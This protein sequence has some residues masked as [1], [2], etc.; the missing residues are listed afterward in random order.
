M[1]PVVSATLLTQMVQKELDENK[2]LTN[3]QRARLMEAASRA[4][5]SENR[6]K[7]QKGK[8]RQK[9]AKQGIKRGAGRP[10]KE[11]PF[12]PTP[13]KGLNDFLEATGGQENKPEESAPAVLGST[14]EP[15][16]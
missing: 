12:T 9:L 7:I 3:E 14:N 4:I 5:A 6:V 2:T 16:A 15:E 8:E 13:T 10:T 1:P 11:K